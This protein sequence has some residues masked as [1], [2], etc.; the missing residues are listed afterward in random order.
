MRLIFL[1][2]VSSAVIGLD[3]VSKWWIEQNISFE[4]PLILIPNF[5]QI[6]LVKNP[7]GVFGIF[8]DFVG[9]YFRFLFIL[10]TLITLGLVGFLYFKLPPN[11]Y[12]AA[13]GLSLIIGGAIGNLIDRL[14]LG[15]VIDFIDLHYYSYHWPAFNVADSA[16]TVGAGILAILILLKKW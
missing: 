10:F 14:R 2:V 12:S 11:L 15:E 6:T 1:L 13:W 5:L 3:Q 4:R 9:D 8:S 7:G 16:I